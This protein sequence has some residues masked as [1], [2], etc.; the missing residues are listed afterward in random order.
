M[1]PGL[2]EQHVGPEFTDL[3]GNPRTIN[4]ILAMDS[5]KDQ[6]S[7]GHSTGD[8]QPSLT[9]SQTAIVVAI[10]SLGTVIG[11]LLAAPLG[12][13]Y[14]RRISLI[15]AVTV[16]NFGV[17]FQVCADAIPMLLVGR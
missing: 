16:F 15:G 13:L 9:P 7:T 3:V 4:G 11:A 12:D 8:G 2:W 1:R 17:I 6:F 10:L 14:G 5:F